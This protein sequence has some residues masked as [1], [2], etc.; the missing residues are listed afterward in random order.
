[1]LS[2]LPGKAS[3]CFEL[4]G[5]IS[6]ECDKLRKDLQGLRSQ[7]VLNILNL[8]VDGFAIQAKQFKKFSQELVARF[9]MLCDLPA[10]GC[11]GEATV[12]LIINE[13]PAGQAADHVRNRRGAEM[14]TGSQV[15]YPGVSF[16]FDQ[17]V[18][19]LQMILG[20]L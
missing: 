10:G 7:V 9:D 4:V 14:Q 12:P 20:R 6:P 1:M 3:K 17:F 5:P 2:F 15:S 19:A 11:Q 16:L 8:T 18:N 13:A